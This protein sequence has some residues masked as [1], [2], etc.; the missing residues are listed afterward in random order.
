MM[1]MS[2]LS[3]TF[4]LPLWFWKYLLR[5]HWKRH[6]TWPLLP[7][8]KRVQLFAVQRRQT[9]QLFEVQRRQAEDLWAKANVGLTEKQLICRCWRWQTLSKWGKRAEETWKSSR[10]NFPPS[11]SSS[12]PNDRIC[13]EPTAAITWPVMKVNWVDIGLGFL[14]W[15]WLGLDCNGLN[16]AADL[17]ILAPISGELAVEIVKYKA[18]ETLPVSTSIDRPFFYFNHYSDGDPMSPK[19]SN[20]P[21]VSNNCRDVTKAEFG[22][23]GLST[24]LT[25]CRSRVG[26]TKSWTRCSTRKSASCLCWRWRCWWISTDWIR[27]ARGEIAGKSKVVSNL[28][29]HFTVSRWINWWPRIDPFNPQSKRPSSWTRSVVNFF[30]VFLFRYFGFDISVSMFRPPTFRPPAFQPDTGESF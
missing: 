16:Q 1:M 13:S 23:D 6:W 22:S 9:V 8:V 20:G 10:N 29:V 14:A 18:K 4:W 3:C 12:N 17:C 25:L 26:R 2:N 21:P 19:V 15:R 24:D 11:T 27:V 30:T 5:D 28:K 7:V